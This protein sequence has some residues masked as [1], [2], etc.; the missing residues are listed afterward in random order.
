MGLVYLILNIES[1]RYKIGITSGKTSKRIN[2]L[3]TG[4]DCELMLIK[5]YETNHYKKLEIMLHNHYNN[6]RYCREWFELT[7]EDVKSFKETCDNLISIINSLGD[8]PFF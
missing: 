6:K 8:N 3:K 2:N 7:A 5:T 4:N 1:E